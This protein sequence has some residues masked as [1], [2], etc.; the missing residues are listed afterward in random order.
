MMNNFDQTQIE[1]AVAELIRDLG[2]SE[3]VFNN[4][5]RSSDKNLK[6]FVVCRVVGNIRDYGAFGMCRV[7]VQLY[8][9]DVANMKNGQKLSVMQ[10]KIKG[11]ITSQIGN[12][13]LDFKGVEPVGDTP[14]G[15]G[16][17]VRILQLRQVIIK[18]V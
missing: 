3:N 9:Q 15:N 8:A 14:D 10:G 16:Y 11:G 18:I 6:D 17:H 13:L 5:P 7:S 12:M 2:V 1:T 4:R